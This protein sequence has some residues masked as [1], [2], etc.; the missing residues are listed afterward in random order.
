MSDNINQPPHYTQGRFQPIDVIEDW[1]LG[2]H[3]G[4]VLKYIRRWQD[5]N[6]IEDLKK[7]LWYLQ[8][9][10]ELNDTKST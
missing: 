6:G 8:R 9:F 10:V 2:Y 4:N 1:N 5:K 7:A 3:E